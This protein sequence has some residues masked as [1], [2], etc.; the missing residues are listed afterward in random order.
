[1]LFN[2]S[3]EAAITAM[4]RL[5]EV[6]DQCDTTLNAAQIA[7]DRKLKKPFVAKLLTVLSAHGLVKGFPGRVGGYC[8]GKPPQEIT[9]AE[10]ADCF[11]RKYDPDACPLGLDTCSVE[12]GPTCPV[13]D[14]LGNIK[15][16][17][18]RFL[19]DTTLASFVK[20]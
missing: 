14:K 10:I 3:T 18:H 8:L 2:R 19:Q 11:E 13:H 9:L 16:D 17:L 4:S 12:S 15:R 5:A 20:G 1:M 7:E 6:Y